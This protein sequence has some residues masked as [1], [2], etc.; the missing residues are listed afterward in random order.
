MEIMN[1]IAHVFCR[2]Y[3][4]FYTSSI[5]V[6]LPCLLLTLFGVIFLP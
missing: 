6:V 4:E 5:L 3:F 2:S 1:E